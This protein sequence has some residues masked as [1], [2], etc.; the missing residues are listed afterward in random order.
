MF[1]NGQG[2]YFVIGF[3]F[4]VFALIITPL[5]LRIAGFDKQ[6][7]SHARTYTVLGAAAFYTLFFGVGIIGSAVTALA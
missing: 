5:I 2:I 4:G 6:S 7:K 3:C 1:R